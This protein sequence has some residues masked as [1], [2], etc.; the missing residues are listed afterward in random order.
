MSKPYRS[1][2]CRAPA[3]VGP[4][5]K[6]KLGKLLG[7]RCPKLG[8]KGHGAWYARYEAPPDGDGKRRQPRIGPYPTERECKKALVEV[9]G[10]V[11]AGTHAADRKLTVGAYLDSWLEDQ[12][13]TLKPG[14]LKSY[15]EAVRLYFRPGLGHIKL[16]DLRDHHVRRLYAAM[17]KINRPEAADD[18][19]EMLRRLLGARASVPHLPGKLWGVKPL[20]EAG[21]RRRHAVISAALNDAV[22]RHLIPFSP[23]ATVKFK[24][25]KA[26]P[27]LWT[28]ARVQRWGETGK[29]PAKVMVWTA[30]QAGAFLDSIEDDR[31]YPLYHVAAYWG[32]RRG[33]LVG[34]PWGDLDLKTRRLHVRQAQADGELDSVKSEDSDRIIT[35][36]AQT[37]AV[38]RAWKRQQAAERL[39]WSGAWVDS[40]RVFTREDGSPQRPAYVSDHFEVLTAQAKLPPVRF[41]DLRHGA[42]TMLIAAGQPIKVVSAILGHSTSAFTMDIYA[43]VAE[44]LAEAAAVA[45]AA[46][47][48]RKAHP[49]AAQ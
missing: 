23:A 34:L 4:D 29:R 49:E 3:T 21:I 26:R 1:C 47:V 17:R 37:A 40:G 39:A 38:L 46:F 18:Q 8:Q 43:V 2:N 13:A 11:S 32:L 10:Q 16:C 44:E 22:E 41:H 15:R 19:D 25:R 31:L 7:G 35:I 14:T 28:D 27:L 30:A 33:E 9:L 12:A 48:P 6:K 36:D 45:I 20:V 24:L 42:A 5:G